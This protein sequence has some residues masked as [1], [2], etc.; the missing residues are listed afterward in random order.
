MANRGYKASLKSNGEGGYIVTFKGIPE[1]I[2]EI[3]SMEEFQKT[4]TDCL[5]TAIDFYI[6][7]RKTFPL[8]EE[9]DEN[10]KDVVYLPVSVMAKVLLLNTMVSCNIRPVDL[11][12][13][14]HIHPQDVTRILNTNHTTKIDTLAKALKV[15]GKNLQVSI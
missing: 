11:A 14:M 1:A 15:L 6:E 4:A 2:T 12:K 7:D 5:I 10:E 9:V 8:P 3:W 13:K